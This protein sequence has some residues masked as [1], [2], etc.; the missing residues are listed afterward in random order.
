MRN[1]KKLNTIFPDV[2]NTYVVDVDTLEIF[3]WRSSSLRAPVV[4]SDGRVSVQKLNGKA[5]LVSQR[6]LRKALSE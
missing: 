1:L 5:R 2:V 3:N 6:Q 4:R